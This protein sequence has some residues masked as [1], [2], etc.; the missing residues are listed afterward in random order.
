MTAPVF[1]AAI[2]SL[3][4]FTKHYEYPV[5]QTTGFRGKLKVIKG[6][7]DEDLD[8]QRWAF[9]WANL[10]GTLAVVQD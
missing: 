8:I 2:E 6:E 7:E 1:Q 10:E 5:N 3:D 9:D 4:Q